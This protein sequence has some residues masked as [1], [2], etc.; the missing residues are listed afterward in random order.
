MT[1]T[2]LSQST[3]WYSAC[4]E[5]TASEIA[6]LEPTGKRVLCITASGSRAFDLL[7]ADPAHILSIDENPAQTALAKLYA[8]AYSHYDYPTFCALLGLKESSI[9][10]TLLAR[11]LPH[12][13]ETA[14]TFWQRNQ[15]LADMGL[16]YCGRWEGFMRRIASWS[17]KKRHRLAQQLLS[18]DTVEAQW[19]LWQTRWDDWQWRLFLRGLSCRP[20]WRWG[21]KEPGISFV[22][23]T[24]DIMGYA[25][26]R[27]E[28]A[29]KNLY[30]RNLPFAW[31]VFT[32]AYPPHALPPYLTEAG[33]TTIRERIGRLTLKTASLQDTVAADGVDMFDAVSLS[34]YSSY[35]DAAEQARVWQ[36]LR[37]KVT[38]TGR[39]CERKFFNKSGT[40]APLGAGFERLTSLENTLNARD[41]AW[42]YTFV[43]AQKGFHHGI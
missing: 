40:E 10:R 20:L 12:L 28:H 29:A 2:Q 4:N 38:V 42:F 9:R 13:S 16:L 6:A 21:F 35:C 1:A 41:G 15:H 33:H 7:L 39:V 19:L 30:L 14:Q 11:L 25:R 5:D 24:F 17:G 36:N 3:I 27:F 23:K 37:R 31:L 22:P 34:D 43:I 26:A 32:G 18:C 8:A